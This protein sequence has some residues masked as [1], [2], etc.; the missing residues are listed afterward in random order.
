MQISRR[1]GRVCAVVAGASMML[2][3]ALCNGY[4]LLYPDSISYLGDGRPLAR[5]L[6][7]HGPKG[8]SAMR[9]EIYALGIF[10]FHWNVT[11]W[12]IAAMQALL[13]SYVLWLVVRSLAARRV[14]L[15]FLVMVGVLCLTTSLGWYACLIL[16]DIMGPVLYLSIYL[17]VFARE[18]LTMRERWAVSGIAG[19]TMAA[20]STH[21]ILACGVCLLLGLLLALRWPPM[22]ARGRGVAWVAS[23]AVLTA[24]TQMVLH[25]YLYGKPS[26]NGNRL[27]YLTARIVA[28]GPGRWYLQQHCGQL[29]WAVCT[30]AGNL[31]QTD[32]DFLWADSGVWQSASSDQQEQML[33]QE[34][35][36]ALATLRAYPEAQTRVSFNNFREEM[37]NFG[38]WDFDPN[39]W[40]ESHIDTVLTGARAHYLRTR[41]AQSRLPNEFFSTVQQWAVMASAL[42]IVVGVPLLWNR[43]RRRILGL[44]ATVVPVVIAN[45]FVT[46]VFS[47][48]DSRY[49]S[50]VIWLVPLTAGLIA[51]DLMH[52]RRTREEEDEL[53]EDPAQPSRYHRDCYGLCPRQL[54]FVHLQPRAVHGR[55]W[56]GDGGAPQRRADARRGGGTAAE[57]HPDIAGA[58]YAGGC[59][60]LD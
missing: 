48:V 8:Y 26:L 43:Q 2:W 40:V 35:P 38:L 54:R 32:D 10:S 23:I 58:V 19:W 33:R 16:P 57:P 44:A 1:I 60:H 4:P 51:L 41:Q 45:A 49:Q 34:I 59:G 17:L 15:K 9:S 7:L 52:I 6:F 28:D 47:E 37:G 39:Q 21:L 24:G 22:R 46:A 36:L 13:T 30:W 18:T 29:Q 14:E 53:G 56:G 12:P 27:P 20:H 3:P 25:D 31:P 55:A 11:A 50:R 5:I 42:A